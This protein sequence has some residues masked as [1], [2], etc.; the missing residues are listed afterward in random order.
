MQQHSLSL[1]FDKEALFATSRD[2]SLTRNIACDQYF[3]ARFWWVTSDIVRT[4]YSR[5]KTPVFRCEAL[6]AKQLVV[7]QGIGHDNLC[8]R[9]TGGGAHSSAARR[10]QNGAERL[11]KISNNRRFSLKRN[12]GSGRK[13]ED[14]A[15]AVDANAKLPRP[16]LA[17]VPNGA[18]NHDCNELGL[19]HGRYRSCPIIETR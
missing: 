19:D 11:G 2:V 9:L 6:V 14:G 1:L 16:S 12:F 4:Q 3:H 10:Y 5:T 8:Y 18:R 13:L 7:A 17:H 15:R